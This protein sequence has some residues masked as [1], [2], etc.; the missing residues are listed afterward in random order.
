MKKAFILFALFIAMSTILSGQDR[1][2]DFYITKSGDTVLGSYYFVYGSKY[3]MFK[4]TA[5][6]KIKLKPDSVLSYSIYLENTNRGKNDPYYYTRTW[7]NVKGV[8]YGVLYRSK[9]PV[10]ILLKEW[11]SLGPAPSGGTIYYFE[12][13]DSL[14]QFFTFYSAA[15]KYLSDC[16][17]VIDLLDHVPNQRNKEKTHKATIDDAEFIISKYNECVK[18]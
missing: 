2:N 12:R 15:K 11:S 18:H 5:G 13:N 17:A 10:C 16:P 3:D 14:T 4:T 1:P 9:G 6:E 8:F 7:Q